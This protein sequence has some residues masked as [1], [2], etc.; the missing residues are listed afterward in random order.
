MLS[1]TMPAAMPPQMPSGA[2]LAFHDEV[3]DVVR[4]PGPGRAAVQP[5][6]DS[7]VALHQRVAALVVRQPG[8]RHAHIPTM[9][10]QRTG[11]LMVF[12]RA[13]AMP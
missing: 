8:K 6:H 9:R 4:K 5:V 10:S 3:P 13:G 2:Q 11:G 7:V 1:K 12:A